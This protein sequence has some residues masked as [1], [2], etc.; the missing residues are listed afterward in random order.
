MQRPGTF[1]MRSQIFRDL[2]AEG[3]EMEQEELNVTPGDLVYARENIAY[4]PEH[5]APDFKIRT[6]PQGTPGV[7]VGIENTYQPRRYMVDFITKTKLGTLRVYASEI[8][9]DS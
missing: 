1:K 6:I 8:T 2:L 3:V 5:S 7:L 9:T 4:T